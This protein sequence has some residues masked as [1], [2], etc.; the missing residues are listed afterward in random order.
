MSLLRAFSRSFLV[1]VG[2]YSYERSKRHL[3]LVPSFPWPGQCAV[4]RVVGGEMAKVCISCCLLSLHIAPP[5][6]LASTATTATT[7]TQ[8]RQAR[9]SQLRSEQKKTRAKAG[10]LGRRRQNL[11]QWRLGEYVAMWCRMRGECGV[12]RGVG[13]WIIP[14]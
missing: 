6:I 3:P 8:V 13:K 9:L 4:N 14:G 1:V 12:R 7:A 5:H 10:K 2:S 11:H